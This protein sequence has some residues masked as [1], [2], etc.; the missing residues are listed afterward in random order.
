MLEN[1]L[2]C[3][4]FCGRFLRKQVVKILLDAAEGRFGG[5][6]IVRANPKIEFDFGFRPG[7]ANRKP[8]VFKNV[9]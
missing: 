7:R 1:G 6:L 2:L 4:R 3:C 9:F 8:A 5:V